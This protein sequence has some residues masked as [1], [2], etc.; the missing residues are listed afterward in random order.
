MSDFK[1]A[2]TEWLE[3]KK[4]IAQARKDMSVLTKRE[5]VLSDVIK[6]NMEQNEVD[7]VK[8]QDK[9]VRMRIKNAKGSITKDVIQT[10]LVTY[11]SG[12]SVKVEG[13]MKAIIDSAPV[14][15]RSTLSVL[16]ASS[17]N[18]A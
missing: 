14:K 8:I 9:K 7:D 4:H 10:G 2:V 5:K 16:K 18:N 3:L 13:A 6:Q 12:D 1:N 11:F 15:Q 17:S